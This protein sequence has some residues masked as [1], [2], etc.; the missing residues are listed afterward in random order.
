[1]SAI[2][3]GSWT[4]NDPTYES[5]EVNEGLAV[6]PWAGHRDFVYDLLS[7]RRPALVVE[8]GTHYGCSL[9]A[10][11]Q[12]VKD[13]GLPTRLVAVD[14]WEGD[15]HA[16]QYGREV[17]DTVERTVARSFGGVQLTLQRSTF[18]DA[19][20]V[21]EDASVD[22]LHIDGFHSYEAV[23]EDF[24]TWLPKLA[25]DAIVLFH[26]VASDNGYES[27]RF[28]REVSAEH[29]AF[30][31]PHSFGLGV[32]FPTGDRWY[33]ALEQE[34]V[35]PWLPAY[36]WR[37]EAQLARR[38]LADTQAQLEARWQVVQRLEEMVGAR[39]EA[40]TAQAA[41]LDERW[42]V[43]QD[44]DR[45]M[46]L[47]DERVRQ[48]ESSVA[49]LQA[50]LAQHRAEQQAQLARHEAELQAQLARHEAE[51]QAQLEQHQAELVAAQE[52]L[53][54]PRVLLRRSAERVRRQV[55]GDRSGA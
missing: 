37:A 35:L 40:L 23:K 32:L 36:R 24:E 31:F 27:P 48:L 47:R 11:A 6:S 25:P 52:A 42:T 13:Q 1:M 28:W 4:W 20:D 51:R 17:L 43:M 54:H 41:L 49:A 15:D 55:S 38:Q 8:L 16:G 22:V 14:T 29:P 45:A 26:D 33:R 44:M 34:G 7:W 10:F 50:E 3:T 21:V 19:R 5:D 9:F 18:L 46:A 12:A 30:D 39:D 2:V 53:P